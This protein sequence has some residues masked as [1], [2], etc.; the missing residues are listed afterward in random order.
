MNLPMRNPLSCLLVCAAFS[1]TPGKAGAT[2]F[3]LAPAK[4]AIDRW[5][6]PFNFQ[7]AERPVAPTYGSFDSRFDTRDA[8]LLLGWDTGSLL[9]TNAGPSRYLLRGVRITLTSVA[10]IAPNLPFVYDPTYD[11]YRTYVTN[12]AESTPDTDPGRPIEMFGVAF[13][14]GFTAETYKQDSAFGPL[15]SI[16][17]DTITIASRNAYAGMFDTNGVLADV[18]NSVGQRN[19]GWTNAPFE[20]RPFAIGTTTAVA[21]GQEMPDGG[22]M[23]FDVDL[24][25]PLVLGYVQSAL[26]DGRL[27]L[28]VASLSPAGQSTPGGTGAG[29]A[30]AYPWWATS[31]NLVYEGPKLRLEGTLVTDTDTDQ[32]G[33][34]DDW[35]R[36]W[37]ND[38]SATADGDD[39]GDG[40]TNRQ[41]YQAGTNPREASSRLRILTWSLGPGGGLT[42]EFPIAASRAYQLEGSA[43]LSQWTPL[44]GVVSYPRPGTARWVA[45][46]PVTGG[47]SGTAWR[48]FRVAVH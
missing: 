43:D 29:G 17:S 18:G 11:S 6:Y 13:R 22:T 36:F 44:A 9:S 30:G 46:G 8:E 35:E 1:G 39:D 21:P 16:T 7:P 45:S 27:R 14:G 3:L 34:P 48:F 15:G 19:V 33:L 24:T 28:M 12:L 47:A 23:D 32:D 20:T 25:D 40:A 31:K 2:D 26:N 5:N 37:W 42:V 41:E 10:P 4:P 38:L